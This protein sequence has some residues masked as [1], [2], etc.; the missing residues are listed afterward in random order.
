MSLQCC[1]CLSWDTGGYSACKKILLTVIPKGSGLNLAWSNSSKECPLIKQKEKAEL[2]SSLVCFFSPSV[3][4]RVYRIYPD[5]VVQSL[6][7][8]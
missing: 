3:E 6:P 1:D 7:G 8:I 5:N 4:R 2:M